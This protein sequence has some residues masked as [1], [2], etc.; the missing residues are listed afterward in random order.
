MPSFISVFFFCLYS[1]H[2]RI[3]HQLFLWLL[4]FCFTKTGY[5]F[6]G[7]SKNKSCLKTCKSIVTYKV[8]LMT[9]KVDICFLGHFDKI[10]FESCWCWTSCRENFHFSDD[11]TSEKDSCVISV[12]GLTE[13]ATV[14]TIQPPQSSGPCQDLLPLTESRCLSLETMGR[15]QTR[16]NLGKSSLAWSLNMSLVKVVLMTKWFIIA[17]IPYN[18]NIKECS[19]NSE[20][21]LQKWTGFIKFTLENWF[22]L[23]VMW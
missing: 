17:F 23:W 5:D 19:N 6:L 16:G 22:F 9:F 4:V 8:Q 11:E 14:I 3:L 13:I 1:F 12:P 21:A 20:T 2:P 18:I 10:G 15:K 7:I